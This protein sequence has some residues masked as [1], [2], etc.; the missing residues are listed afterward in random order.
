M[1]HNAL[2]YKWGNNSSDEK[3]QHNLYHPPP[4]P[5]P[6]TWCRYNKA[7]DNHLEYKHK[8]KLPYDIMVLTLSD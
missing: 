2:F 8:H 3:P 4:T 6:D 7:T 5:G 1:V